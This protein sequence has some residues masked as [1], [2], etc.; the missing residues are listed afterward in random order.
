M[1]MGAS[2]TAAHA[3]SKKKAP[4]FTLF[5]TMTPTRASVTA[6]HAVSKKKV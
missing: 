5:K 6:A 1:G 3:V 4:N 2:V